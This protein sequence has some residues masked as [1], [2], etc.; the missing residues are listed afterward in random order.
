MSENK[1]IEEKSISI[2]Q[3]K[4]EPIWTNWTYYTTKNGNI[5]K[6]PMSKVN[7]SA[8]RV[9]YREANNRTNW[10]KKTMGVGIIFAP[11]S[12]GLA[13]CGCG[14]DIDSHYVD[15]NPLS[16]EFLATFNDTYIEQSPFGKGY[17]ILFFAKLSC[18]LKYLKSIIVLFLN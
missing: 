14:I 1:L 3:L 10:S 18:I 8:M 13:I 2:T 7:N 11:H 17:H 16:K 5:T 4:E 6:R 15:S 9:T 12:S